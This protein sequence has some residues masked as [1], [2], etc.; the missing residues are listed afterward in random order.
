MI[1]F[2][3]SVLWSFV[4]ACFAA[5]GGLMKAL[6]SNLKT[7]IAENRAMFEQQLTDIKDQTNTRWV[8]SSRDRSEMRQELAA[9]RAETGK[10]HRELATAIT[11]LTARIAALPTRQELRETIADVVRD[12]D[13]R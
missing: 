3:Q 13:R 4:G 5:I 9:Q 2:D 10:S 6:H 8:E 1:Q 11:E 12:R 7:S